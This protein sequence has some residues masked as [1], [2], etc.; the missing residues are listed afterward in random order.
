MKH[1]TCH[2]WHTFKNCRYLED[3]CIYSHR[4]EGCEGI[5]SKPIHKE[6]GKPAV[7]GKNAERDNPDYTDWARIH[8]AF[9]P[10]RPKSPF[11]PKIQVQIENIHKKYD[12]GVST[13]PDIKR[14]QQAEKHAIDMRAIEAAGAAVHQARLDARMKALGELIERLGGGETSRGIDATTPRSNGS[15]TRSSSAPTLPPEANKAAKLD[16]DTRLITA[17][18]T[19][20]IMTDIVAENQALRSAVQ[21]LAEVVSTLMTS[22]VF[23]RAN[24]LSLHDSLFD[25]ILKLPAEWHD[26][27]LRPFA[28]S[29]QGFQEIRHG[30]EQARMAIAAIRAKMI[31]MGQGGLLTAWD[32]DVCT[33]IPRSAQ[34]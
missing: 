5:A 32:R 20:T 13:D 31:E 11:H 3:D 34:D 29:T 18:D 28:T 15:A 33:S 27:L 6:P 10:P 17:A 2:Y 26:F 8:A 22:N 16:T 30:E 21:D 4:Y 25:K 7:A 23:L 19:P 1:L 24:R 9:N 12:A 14:L